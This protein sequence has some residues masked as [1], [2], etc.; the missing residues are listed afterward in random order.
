MS[1]VRLSRLNCSY[2]GLHTDSVS[3]HGA[4]QGA[5]SG[6]THCTGMARR[7]CLDI[8]SGWLKMTANVSTDSGMLDEGAYH[9]DFA[10]RLAYAMI[11]LNNP[12]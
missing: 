3:D 10:S 8:I 6:T 11:L 7:L 2:L 5:M 1:A 12:K 4:L 9:S